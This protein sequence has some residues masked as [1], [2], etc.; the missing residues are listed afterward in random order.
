MTQTSQ[1]HLCTGLPSFAAED[2]GGWA[3]LA[4]FAR[5]ADTAGVDTL[6]ISDHV[7]FGEQLEEYAKPEVGGSKGGKQPT[8]PDGHWLEPITTIAW[9][10]G[11]TQRVG[12]RTNILLAALRRPVVLAKMA[13]NIDVLSGGRLALGVGVGWQ[14]A[15]YEAAGLDFEGRGKLLDHVDRAHA[16]LGERAHDAKISREDR[17]GLENP[18]RSHRRDDSAKTRTVS[19]PVARATDHS[20]RDIGVGG[21]GW[22]MAP[23]RARGNQPPIVGASKRQR[24]A[25]GENRLPQE[26]LTLPFLQVFS[27][28]LRTFFVSWVACWFLPCSL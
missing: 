10:A 17:A 11:Q 5:A 24:P 16:S 26:P 19:N 13:A 9:L 27:C 20:R 6:L 2:P 14:A 21:I 7:V 3:P 8:G 4:T 12:Y 23:A 15:E 1:P 22:R 18:R 28:A 25:H